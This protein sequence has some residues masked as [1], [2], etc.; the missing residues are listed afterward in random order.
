MEVNIFLLGH[1]RTK[2]IVIKYGGG[3][4]QYIDNSCLV[5]YLPR[6]A[7]KE[8]AKALDVMQNVDYCTTPNR[9]NRDVPTG[10]TSQG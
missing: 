3:D 8:V 10:I 9:A 2:H 6:R 1:G 4:T 5:A 7:P